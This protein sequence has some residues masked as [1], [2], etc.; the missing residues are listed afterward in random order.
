MEFWGIQKTEVI[1]IIHDNKGKLI[2]IDS[3]NDCPPWE[4]YLYFV[5]K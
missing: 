4:S 2:R 5:T 1:D 3:N